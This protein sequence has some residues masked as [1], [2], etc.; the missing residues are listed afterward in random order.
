ML[1]RDRMIRILLVLYAAGS[2]V[3]ALP[4]LFYGHAGDL[5]ET[6]SGRILAAA[7]LAMAGAAAAA[8][9]NP[10]ANRLVIK[11]L[12]AFSFMSALAIAYRVAAGNHQED[13]AWFLLPLAVA[14][15]IVL[16]VLYPRPPK[17]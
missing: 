6:T 1:S 17:D 15:P 11:M 4:L 3:V 13:P 5:S 12:I 7:L 16:A 8:A 9:R 14:A 2:V 10:W